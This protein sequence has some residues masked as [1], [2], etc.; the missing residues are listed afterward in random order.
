ME[1]S[2]HNG[3]NF[4]YV[5]GYKQKGEQETQIREIL[6]WRA[7]EVVIPDQP[8]FTEYEIF[9]KSVNIKGEAPA[10]T[11]RRR[12]GYSGQGSK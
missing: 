7:N 12:I 5:V 1:T 11:L 10:S 9:V 3:E 6:D 8:T 4:R 2:D